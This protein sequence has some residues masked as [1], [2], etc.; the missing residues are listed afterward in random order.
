MPKQYDDDPLLSPCKCNGS[1]AYVH[2]SCITKWQQYTDNTEFM[3]KCSVCLQPYNGLPY[4]E[5]YIPEVE[6]T[7]MWAILSRFYLV[8]ILCDF[9]H[10]LYHDDHPVIR[11]TE[12][13]SEYQADAKNRFAYTCI[14]AYV[15]CI[16]G[17][18]YYNLVRTVKNKC[19]YLSY[20]L[21]PRAYDDLGYN[22]TWNPQLLLLITIL[23]YG[24][25]FVTR[26]PFH[27][28]YLYMLPQ[29][30]YTHKTILQHMNIEIVARRPL[31]RA[32]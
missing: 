17:L 7:R 20:W 27:A 12:P 25:T 29:Y 11:V 22:R 8:W 2:T 18:F 26:G 10:F 4:S 23:T 21:C 16:Y 5:E 15:S 19:T 3:R 30:Y 32:A 24:V 9:I 14:L 28:L 13:Y 6:D 1:M 31:M